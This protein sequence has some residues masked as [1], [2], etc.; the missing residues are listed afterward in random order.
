MTI[1][2]FQLV[3]STQYYE[4]M[5]SEQTSLNGTHLLQS[6]I[7]QHVIFPQYCEYYTCR[8]DPR[9]DQFP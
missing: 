7:A 8:V 6:R 2:N 3:L 1:S 4:N 5:Q 9:E